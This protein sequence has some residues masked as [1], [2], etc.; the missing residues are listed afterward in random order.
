MFITIDNIRYAVVTR[1]TGPPMLCLHGFAEN[2]STWDFIHLEH[3]QM[4]L[5]D[6]IGHGHSDKPES[7]A[8]YR[9]SAII[10]QLHKLMQLLGHQKYALMGY[11]M[12]GRLA[13]AYTLAYPQEITR[14]V[15]E[16]SSYGECDTQN[17]A[18]R[19]N[20]DV[21]LAKAIL[22]NGIEWF[23]GYWSGLDLFTSQQ[24]LPHNIRD[25]ISE[26]RLLNLPHALANTLLGN[27]QGNFPCLQEQITHLSV[28][29]LYINGEYDDKYRNIG[30]EFAQLNPGIRRETIRDAGHNNHIEKPH[31]F[32]EV[33]NNWLLY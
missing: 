12:G 25:K 4:V 29:V 11:S 16:S 21:W 10:G 22:V 18:R 27:G 28:P 33:V 24:N 15:L 17:R 23:N 8:P 32:N 14:L 1:G 20:H 30:A 5:V 31:L 2:F 6:L 19:R 26:R 13:L 7:L 9:V 3:C